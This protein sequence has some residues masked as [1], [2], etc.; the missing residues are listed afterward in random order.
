[1]ARINCEKHDFAHGVNLVESDLFSALGDRKYDIIV[2]NPPYVP[3]EEMRVLPAEYKH[4][5]SLALE[6]GATGLNVVNRILPEARKHMSPHG[7]LVVE[8]GNGRTALEAKYPRIPFTW[9]DFE[10]GGEG[11]FVISGTDLSL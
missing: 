2:S 11:V 3:D 1:M 8:T 5:P 9:P 10:Y 4:E 6:A 7:I